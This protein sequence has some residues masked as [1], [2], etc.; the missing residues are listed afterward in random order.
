MIRFPRLPVS[1]TK[2]ERQKNGDLKT[3]FMVRNLHT[4]GTIVNTII[5][6]AKFLKDL[7]C[8]FLAMPF[9]TI[10]LFNV[11]PHWYQKHRKNDLIEVKQ[12]VHLAI[13]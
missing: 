1:K 4:I 5:N 13:P 6:H 8:H 2:A 9:S 11:L 7:T 3:K 10:F 12:I